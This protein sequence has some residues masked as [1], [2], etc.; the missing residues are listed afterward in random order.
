[1]CGRFRE[2][3]EIHRKEQAKKKAEEESE[4]RCTVF[5]VLEAGGFHPDGLSWLREK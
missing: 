4:E 1:M 5:S 2:E 3:L